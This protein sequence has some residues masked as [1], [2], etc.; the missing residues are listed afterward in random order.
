MKR[1]LCLTLSLL[2]A[3]GLASSALAASAENNAEP[4]EPV[5]LLKPGMQYLESVTVGGETTGGGFYVYAPREPHDYDILSNCMNGVI[6]VYT[7]KPV[8]NETAAR[9]LVSRLELDGIAEGFPAYIVIPTPLNGTSWT[10]DDLALYWEAQFALAGGLVNVESQPPQGEYTRHTMNTLQYVIGEGSGATFI[11]NVLSQNAVRIAGIAAF[12]GEIDAELP[13]GLSVPAYLVDP[14]EEVASYWKTANGTDDEDGNVFY[15][16]DYELKKV[17]VAEGSGNFDKENIQQAWTDVLSKS[18]RLGVATNVVL[19][20]M[21]QSEWILMDWLELDDIG[22]NRYSFE[23]DAETGEAE[24]YTEYKTKS[25][26]SVHLYVPEAVENDPDTAVPLLVALHGGSDDPLNIVM[27]CGWANKAVEENFIIVSPSN[28]EPKYV[29]AILDYVD[30]LYNVDHSRMYVSGFFMGGVGSSDL[31]NPGRCVLGHH[32]GL[33]LIMVG[34]AYSGWACD[35][36]IFPAR[37]SA[38]LR[39]QTPLRR[40]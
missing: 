22:L 35:G 38:W 36:F 37:N 39:R 15:N 28:E 20:T 11:H 25:L 33:L 4:T 13:V 32:P 24:Y 18:M 3:F 16:S 31:G 8:K 21:D 26:D 14:S 6:F 27:G 5:E 7:D 12:G 30:T 34:F 10:D 29:M 23:F 17:V 2:M 19:T 40:G 1:I 9:K